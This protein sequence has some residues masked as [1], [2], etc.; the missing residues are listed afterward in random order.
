MTRKLILASLLALACGCD[1]VTRVAVLRSA[2]D[3]VPAFQVKAQFREDH[4]LIDARVTKRLPRPGRY[5]ALFCRC[6]DRNGLTLQVV[7]ARLEDLAHAHPGAG[8]RVLIRV[9]SGAER[10]E[11]VVVERDLT[12]A[13]QREDTP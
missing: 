12:R 10:V 1:A 13:P 4:S 2:G 6:F 8:Q 11:V 3:T 7:Q 9:P 5:P